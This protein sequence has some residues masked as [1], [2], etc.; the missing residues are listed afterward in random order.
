MRA[1]LG[2]V[3]AEEQHGETHQTA[4]PST[5]EPKTQGWS[6]DERKASYQSPYVA[7]EPWTAD[8]SGSPVVRQHFAKKRRVG[9]VHEALH[10]RPSEIRDPDAEA[11]GEQDRGQRL[12]GGI[13]DRR[14]PAR[15]RVS[16]ISGSEGEKPV[17]GPI[18]G[19]RIR[20]GRCGERVE[21]RLERD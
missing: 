21:N 5:L 6:L 18:G 2:E 14:R 12:R 19:R 8:S 9:R 1:L 3:H 16:R 10:L 15:K 11:E 13:S 20:E 7:A 4:T 17:E